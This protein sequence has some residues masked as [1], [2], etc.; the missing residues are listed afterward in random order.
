MYKGGTMKNRKLVILAVILIVILLVFVTL[1]SLK[2][3][4]RSNYYKR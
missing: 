1:I 4:Q 2:N 3:T